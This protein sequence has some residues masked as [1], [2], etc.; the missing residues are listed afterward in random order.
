MRV[1]FEYFE[2]PK[3]ANNE[4]INF[5]RDKGKYFLCHIKETKFNYWKTKIVEEK[6]CV[7]YVSINK[8]I[9]LFAHNL[10][11]ESEWEDTVILGYCVL[12]LPENINI[13]I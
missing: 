1:E 2:K 5:L 12:E 11:Y 10:F 9:V 3:K 7:V 8:N 13:S 6:E 4:T